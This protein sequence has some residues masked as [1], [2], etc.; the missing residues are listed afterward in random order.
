[1]LDTIKKLLSRQPSEDKQFTANVADRIFENTAVVRTKYK[2]ISNVINGSRGKKTTFKELRDSPQLVQLRTLLE[3]SPEVSAAENIYK[4]F[5]RTKTTLDADSNNAER[6][7]QEWWDEMEEKGIEQN[8]LIDENIS[9]LYVIG[10]FAMQNI[11]DENGQIV[12]IRNIPPEYI[13]FETLEDEVYK[14]YPAVGYYKD[15]SEGIINK[16]K[17]VP[18]Q[19]IKHKEPNFYYAGMNTKSGSYKG[20]SMICSVIDLAISAGEKEHLLTEYLRG[21]VFPNEIIMVDAEDYLRLVSEGIIEYNDFAKLRKDTVDKVD[22]E[23]G[24]RDATVI[25]TTDI[26][27]KVERTGTLQG[28]LRGLETI[29]DNH[30]VGFPRA[31]KVPQNLLG[32]RR[33]TGGLSTE[34][35]VHTILGFY[36]NILGIRSKIS[37][38]YKKL[39]KAKLV[40]KGS[41]ENCGLAFDNT[42]PELKSMI[43]KALLEESQTAQIHTQM[44]T[45]TVQEIREAFVSGTLDFTMFNPDLPDDARPIPQPAQDEEEEEDVQ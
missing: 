45:F 22:A 25:I 44:G 5:T 2:T 36:K 7:I 31:L 20:Q 39:H 40:E 14:E 24:K 17:F 6:I 26:P 23:I 12:G 42:D 35:N 29:N 27:V 41:D 1:M 16:N 4:S 32:A 3:I 11:G 37:K 33:Q 13:G 10:W 28:G 19:S 21:Q 15:S 43:N 34:S 30:D 18:L 38:G 9:D 8:M